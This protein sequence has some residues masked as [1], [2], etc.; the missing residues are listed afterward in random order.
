MI[1]IDDF[2]K[3][4][5]KVGTIL[6]VE[7]I[8]GSEKLYQLTVELGEERPRTVLSGIKAWYTPEDLKDHQAIFVT[9]LEPRA[10]MGIESQGM[11][12]AVDSPEGPVVLKPEKPT[13]NGSKIR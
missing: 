5:M 13:P 1:T 8:E 9:N 11:I 7:E 3:V 2:A 6:E 12:M 10:M 4:E